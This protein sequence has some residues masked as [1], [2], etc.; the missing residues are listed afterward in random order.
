MTTCPPGPCRAALRAV[1]RP[2][3]G[4]R[5]NDDEEQS[6]SEVFVKRA[7]RGNSWSPRTRSCGSSCGGKGLRHQVW[8]RNGFLRRLHGDHGRPQDC[9]GVLYAFQAKGPR[10]RRPLKRS[11]AISTLPIRSRPALVDRGAPV[12]VLGMPGIVL[13]AKASLAENPIPTDEE[14]ELHMEEFCRARG[15]R[16][17]RVALHKVIRGWIL[18]RCEVNRRI[19]KSSTSPSPRLIRC[20]LALGQAL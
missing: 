6:T 17:S 10:R 15:T 5:G 1:R 7:N 11:S 8:V 20:S 13:A 3:A 9:L 4:E 18:R 2:A 12:R 16:R 19:S 14:I